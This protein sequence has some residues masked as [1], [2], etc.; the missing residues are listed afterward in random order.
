[1]DCNTTATLAKLTCTNYVDFG[2]CQERFGRFS[3]TRNDS[4]YLDLK[5]EVFKREDGNAEFRQR[6]N[7][8]LREADFKQFIRQTNQLAVAANNFLREQNLSPVLQSAL[9]KD[10]EE[11][12]KIVHEV[13][14]V[15]DRP[16]RRICVTLLR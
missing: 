9:S 6:Q 13:I 14:E 7:F 8:S 3:W 11:Q 12:L 16:N 2:K 10:M 15:M 4:N 1:M 5:P